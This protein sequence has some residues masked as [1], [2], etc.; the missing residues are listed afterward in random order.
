MKRML[1]HL[2]SKLKKMISQVKPLPYL[3]IS[4][5][6]SKINIHPTENLHKPVKT[7]YH[8]AVVKACQ[9]MLVKPPD[10]LNED[11]ALKFEQYKAW[12]VKNGMPIEN[13]PMY[14]S[15]N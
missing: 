4:R 13:D 3:S 11:E 8:P 9:M 1:V 7:M 6:I 10:L 5:N 15:R 12:K 2:I 14:K